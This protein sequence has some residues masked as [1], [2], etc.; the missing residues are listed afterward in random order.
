[1][2][3]AAFSSSNFVHVRVH[4][5]VLVKVGW[6]SLNGG[7]GLLAEPISSVRT[8]TGHYNTKSCLFMKDILNSF[9]RENN[10]SVEH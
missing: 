2:E 4:V 5:P 10:W 6:L 3:N 9:S 1:M 7:T 8:Y